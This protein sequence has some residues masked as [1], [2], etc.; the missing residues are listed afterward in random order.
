MENLCIQIENGQPINHPATMDNLMQAF[1]EIP[2]NWEPF[3]RVE[4]PLLKVYEKNQQVSYNKINGIWTDVFTCE[5]MTQEEKVILQNDVKTSWASGN[6]FTSWTF[7][8]EL[9]RFVAP[10]PVPDNTNH[11]LWRE[12]DTS[13]VI[14]PEPPKGDN[15]KFNLELGIW[16]NYE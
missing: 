1:G 16:E 15:W 13:W 5:E 4:A 11:Y 10:S 2:S 7:D 9:C 3:I 12:S 14:L 6:N 8:E